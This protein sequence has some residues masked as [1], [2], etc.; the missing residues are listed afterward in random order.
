MRWRIGKYCKKLA[1]SEED[2]LTELRLAEMTVT[3]VPHLLILCGF[4]QC[5]SPYMSEYR[6]RRAGCGA[7]RCADLC[8]FKAIQ[9]KCQWDDGQG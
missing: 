4:L 2:C 3:S 5:V 8:E 6:G 9:A 7:V 1:T